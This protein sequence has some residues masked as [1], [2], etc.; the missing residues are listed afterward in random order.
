MATCVVTGGSRGIGAAIVK[1]FARRGDRVF[2]L[3]EKEHE[4]AKRVSQ[5]TGATAICCDVADGSAVEEAF[6]AIGNIDI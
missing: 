2:F 5:A 3:Y 4:A 6:R 1:A